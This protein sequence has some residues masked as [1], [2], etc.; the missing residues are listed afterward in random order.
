M[1]ARN[2]SLEDWFARIRSGQLVL[3]RFQRFEAWTYRHVTGL[4]DSVLRELPAGAL[5]TLEIG[6]KE[7]FVS[8]PMAG[9][10]GYGERVSE[11]LLD[12][13][14]RL[15]ALWR[16]LTDDYEDRTY[17]VELKEPDAEGEEEDGSPF[18]AISIGRWERGGK[19]YPMWVDNPTQTWERRAVPVALLRP[20]RKAEAHFRAWAR[21]ATGNDP[22]AYVDLFETGSLLRAKF[23][24]YNLPFLSL[25]NTTSKETALDVFV[26][27][28]TSAQPLSTYDIV[29]AQV[30]AGTGFSLHELVDELR[31]EAPLI[32]HFA[33]PAEI[34]LNAG[35]YIQDKSPRKS[36]LLSQDFCE[37]LI[38]TWDLLVTGSQRAVE[39]LD[40]QQVFDSARLPT[41]PVVPLLVALWAHAPSGLDGE[42]RARSILKRF[43]WLSFFTDRYEMNTTTRGTQ[44]F[45]GLKGM[46]A[47]GTD[48]EPPVFDSASH[49]PPT[50]DDL[51]LAGWPKKKDRLG[52]ALMLLSLRAGG[53]DLADGS[54]AK[55]ENL[56]RREYHH[57]FPV[58]LLRERGVDESRTFRALN[59]ALV[60]WKTNRNISAKSPEEYL[61]HRADAATLGE[62]EV[63]RRLA[64]H[65]IDYDSL[66]HGDYDLFMTARAEM[67]ISEAHS[68]LA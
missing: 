47:G 22:D 5:L 17:L 2:R 56:G 40:E 36:V 15:T 27:M 4:L 61:R 25:P 26:R 23:G 65:L 19:R 38:D 24:N 28:N 68:L 43:L 18:R 45:K 1:E 50:V 44:D 57:L 55:R 48:E 66:V 42:G 51:M 30:E 67:M 13:Q 58:A 16:S 21:E 14:Q 9:V 59:C 39:F 52:R 34:I 11:H 37:A 41:D 62:E 33:D 64:S 8:R 46:I 53:L 12:G 31:K 20:D 6:E 63:R 10:P 29:V 49:P 3:P 32:D 35:A 60:T 54:P 7:P